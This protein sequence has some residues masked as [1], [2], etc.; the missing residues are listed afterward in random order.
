MIKLVSETYGVNYGNSDLIIDFGEPSYPTSTQ[1]QIEIDQQSIDLGLISPHKIL[2]RENPD[3]TEEDARVQV[4]DNINAR[5]E[6]LNKV[7]TGGS[8]NDTMAALGINANT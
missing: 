3:L 8:L 4:D 2:M 5:N 1:E 7:K 6:M